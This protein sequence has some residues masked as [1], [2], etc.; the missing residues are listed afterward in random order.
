VRHRGDPYSFKTIVRAKWDHFLGRISPHIDPQIDNDL[1]CSTLCARAIAIATRTI[2]LIPRDRG[3]VTPA[4]ISASPKLADVTVR[5]C[6]V[7]P[8]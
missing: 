3:L 6:T 2:S 7:Q 5:W 4:V 1:V 8:E